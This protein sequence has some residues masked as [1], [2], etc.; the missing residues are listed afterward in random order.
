MHHKLIN[1]YIYCPQGGVVPPRV[2]CNY[3]ELDERKEKRGAE[4]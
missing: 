4:L 3:D 2:V 1:K